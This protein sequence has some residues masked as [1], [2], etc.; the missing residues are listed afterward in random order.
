MAENE[1][2][3]QAESAENNE[4]KKGKSFLQTYREVNEKARAEEL[5]RESEAEAARA[6]RE[7]QARA[8]YAEKLRQEKLELMKL[9][10]GIIS[11]EDIP[12]EV[13]VQKEYSIWE[14]ISNFFYHN[15]VYIIAAA[16]IAAIA[17]FLIYDLVTTVKPD[18]AVLFIADDSQVQFLTEDMEDLLAKYAQDYNGD[19]KI[20]IRVSYTPASPDL[21]EM[22][23]MYYHGGDQ[24]KLSAEFMGS[25]TIMVIGDKTSCEVVG[26][27]AGDGVFADLNEYFPNDE[28]VMEMGY[29]LNGTSFKKDI[30]YEG[31]SDEL[32]VSFR[33]PF[34]AGLGGSG[35]IK[36]NFDNAIDLW[37][38]YVNGNMIDPDAVSYRK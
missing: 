28:N 21:E 38:N 30:G 22:S 33:Y 8:S 2:N 23:S 5:K 14:K 19:G 6:E 12:K 34:T 17:I 18:V 16:A 15:K 32:W 13:V 3:G 25:D 31:L 20:K 1:K 9:K 37:T 24:V 26:I 4:K 27:T 11:E 10:Q 29:M 7:R 36:E 35:R